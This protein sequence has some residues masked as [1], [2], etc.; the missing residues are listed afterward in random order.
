MA[1]IKDEYIQWPGP[2]T[3]PGA[4]TTPAYDRYAN[5][6]TT[7]H[8]HKGWEWVE[9]DSPYQKAAAALAQSAI[10]TA[11]QRASTVF[12]TVYYQRGNATDR[13]DFDGKAIG[14]T[15]RIQ[16]P[17]TLNIVA[18]WKWTGSAWEKMQ[19]SGEQIS[20]LD[21]GRLT[22]GSASINELAAR[23][24]AADTGKFLQLTTDQLTVT[25]NASFVDLT[26]KHVWARIVSAP[27]GEFEQIKAGMIAANSITANE[28]QA[29]AVDGQVITGATIQ[30]ERTANRGIK[31][32]SSG[33][34]VYASN[35]WKALDINAQTGA[36]SISGHI[37]RRDTWSQ[38]WLND[39][40]SRESGLDEYN[41]FKWGCG[42][43]FNSVE[44]DWW[45]GAISIV[46]AST[47]DPS[48]RIQGPYPKRLGKSSPYISVGTA[49]IAMYTPV[50]NSSFSFNSLGL[51]LQAQE[52]YW[53]MNNQG[54]SFGIK[55]DNL[56][57]LYVGRG[58]L[59]IRTI[60]EKDARFWANKNTTTM[61]FGNQNQV[62]I[63]NNGVHI[64]GTK[65]FSMR[66]PV[67]SAQR[68]GLWLEHA[69]TESPYDGIEYWENIEL[70]AEGHA[71][72]VLPD[73]VPR[74][75]SAKAPWIVLA[76]DGARAVLDRSNTE[77]WHVDVAGAPSTTVAVLVKGAR[78]IDHEVAEDG[79]PV[80]RDYARESP[81]HLPPP[82]PGD[83]SGQGDGGPLSEDMSMGGGLYGP[84][85]NPE[86]ENQ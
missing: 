56:P 30:S 37:S 16:D 45:D 7:V 9:V 86:G 15:C 11:V 25:G 50:A 19:V 69:C 4:A 66:V 51:A 55:S 8:S 62:W 67:L 83:G 72:W 40:V 53:W 38:V 70:D 82:S 27:E 80:M 39:V 85:P 47:G 5:G 60:D 21:V 36:I 78:M 58:E 54:F 71:R 49:A 1:E 24:I 31:I 65:N 18:E 57:R 22:A 42:L 13:P 3:F 34:Q 63:A 46:K 73:Y 52:V 81:W 74:I 33:M 2:A 35:G 75:A 76:S 84:A 68:G 17:T 59:Q 28:L 20:N 43:A 48:L 12:G 64:T 14:D 23:K 79:E 10:E 44:D 32:S 41:G 6:N 61:Q 29:G 26:A 77:E